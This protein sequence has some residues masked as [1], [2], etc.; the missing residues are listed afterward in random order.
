MKILLIITIL[1]STSFSMELIS[2]KKKFK[3]N[4]VPVKIESSNKELKAKLKKRLKASNRIKFSKKH[5]YFL[6][7]IENKKGKIVV[8]IHKK[9]S[10]KIQTFKASN[11]IKSLNNLSYFTQIIFRN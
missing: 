4:I 2:L 7:K 3:S 1:F 10:N 8:E 6:L 5:K 9:N 11:D